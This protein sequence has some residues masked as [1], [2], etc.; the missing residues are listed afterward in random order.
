[1]GG[2]NNIPDISSRFLIPFVTFCLLLLEVQFTYLIYL[3]I[4]LLDTGN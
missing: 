1:M 2:K 4:Y 3:S